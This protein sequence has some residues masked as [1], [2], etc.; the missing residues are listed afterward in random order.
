MDIVLVDHETFAI[1]VV[2]FLRVKGHADAASDFVELWV[3]PECPG[4]ATLASLWIPR[5]CDGRERIL[6]LP[7]ASDADEVEA[8]AGNIDQH[9]DEFRPD[10][11]LDAESLPIR[12]SIEPTARQTSPEST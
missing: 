11:C 10:H 3:A 7:G 5:H 9:A 4:E 1:W 8:C 6:R 12:A 2:S